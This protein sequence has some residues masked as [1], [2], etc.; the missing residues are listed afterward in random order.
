M[1]EERRWCK[2]NT[3]RRNCNRSRRWRDSEYNTYSKEQEQDHRVRRFFL[4]MPKSLLYVLCL[5][6]S[7]CGHL[8]S[9]HHPHCLFRVGPLRRMPSQVFLCMPKSHRP[10]I[11]VRGYQEQDYDYFTTNYVCKYTK[12]SALRLRQGG[13]DNVHTISEHVVEGQRAAR[14]A[15]DLTRS[16]CSHPSLRVRLLG[17]LLHGVP[18]RPPLLPPPPP[19]SPAP[20]GGW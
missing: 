9:P 8:C 20:G 17:Q 6:R 4:C 19:C 10:R 18:L 7:R 11:L 15:A 12:D 5:I 2:W 1:R 13:S 16:D 14:G 3:S